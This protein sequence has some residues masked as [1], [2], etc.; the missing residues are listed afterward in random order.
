MIPYLLHAALL[1]AV[2]LLF[3]KL[4]LQTETFYPLNR[5]IL[6]SCLAFSFLLPL[7]PIPGQW[8]MRETAEPPAMETR[9]Q[10]IV[11]KITTDEAQPVTAPARTK[12]VSTVTTKPLLIRSLPQKPVV[13]SSH[14]TTAQLVRWLFV[15]Y[16]AGVAVFGLNLMIQLCLTFYQ[17]YTKPV[18]NDGPYRIIELSG[19]KVP[20]SFL[21]NIFINPEKYDWETYNQILSHEKVHVRQLHS[22]DI[23]LAELAIVFQWFNPFAWLYRK[24]VEN[25]LEYLT[26]EAVLSGDAMNKESYQVSLLKVSMPQFSLRI[27]TNYNQSLLK[28][29]IL[30]MNAKR[31]N[32]HTLWKYF[33]LLPLFGCL[34]C[35]LNEPAKSKSLIVKNKA[36]VLLMK[37]NA[38]KEAI[39]SQHNFPDETEGNWFATIKHDKVNIEFKNT[40]DDHDWSSSSSFLLHEFSALPK[41]Q[42][43]DF[44]LTRDAGTITFNGKFDGNQGYGHYKFQ[45]NHDYLAYLKNA[46][47]DNTEDRDLLSFLMLN[48]SKSY[49]SSLQENGFTNLTK[50]QLISIAALK[51]DAE[52]IRSWKKAGFKGIT[53]QQLVSAKA[54]GIDSDY[55][56]EIQKAGYPN[57]TFQEL[58][59]FKA[60]GITGSF[61]NGFRKAGSKENL[62][63][64][65]HVHSHSESAASSSSASVST[66]MDIS[67]TDVSSAKALQID[68][69]Y[70]KSFA[71]VG[72]PDLQFYELSTFKVMGVT[73]EYI[74]S[75]QDVGYSNL[76]A[77]VIIS[78]KTM[79][80]T[81]EYIKGFND[82]GYKDIPLSSLTS[83]KIQGVTPEFIKGFE[84]VGYKN[85]EPSNVISLK[86]QGI[87]PAFVK[88]FR[89][90]GYTDT[91]L[92]DITYMK[93]MGVT[94][95][96]VAAMKQKGLNSKDLRKYATLKNSF[97]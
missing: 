7:I 87:T 93:I 4:L 36:N 40:D 38:I 18:I 48:I 51:V 61:V 2:C 24:E 95:E 21:N 13:L 41:E 37:S 32:V 80:V 20:C 27:A 53:P 64:G 79:R 11:P 60:Q 23:L 39:P 91:P 35:A 52:Y 5:W 96:Y 83:F 30:M 44:T 19:D 8:A 89:D 71:K 43:G 94:P 10:I 81:P 54:L 65:T 63:P 56:H 31:S 45:G 50:G 70:V 9:T 14:I 59:S 74:K 57:I 16:W 22:L 90:L 25:N 26:D 28:K 15:L 97:N 66:P 76:P 86:I 82:I 77:H 73:A 47:V 17:A 72:Y 69:A 68:S 46:G 78:L 88:G 55:V 67:V 49:L 75:L 42:K 1:L 29:R 34:A 62:L 92:S 6:Q 85:L 3:Y 12:A 33:M 84:G 58:V